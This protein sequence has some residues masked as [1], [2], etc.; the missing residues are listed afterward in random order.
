[1]TAGLAKKFKATLK[2]EPQQHRLRNICKGFYQ[3]G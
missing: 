2:D 1:M 3:G